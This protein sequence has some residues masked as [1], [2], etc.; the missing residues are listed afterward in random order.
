M[1]P[2]FVLPP[3]LPTLLAPILSAV[4]LAGAAAFALLVYHAI[5][6]H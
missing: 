5:R 1:L 4:V 3:L 6:R 2:T